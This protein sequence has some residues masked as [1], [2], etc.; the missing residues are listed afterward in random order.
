[1]STALDPGSGQGLIDAVLPLRLQDFERAT[2][3]FE[4]LLQNFEG[5]GTLWLVTR[6]EELEAV[7]HESQ[8]I[9]RGLDFRVESELSL[10]PELRLT[11]PSGWYRQ[12]LIKLAIAEHLSSELYLT[13]DADV[14]CTRKVKPRELA[15]GGRG[16]CYVIEK[17]LHPHWYTRSEAVLGLSAVRQGIVHNV[18]PAVLHRTAVRELAEYLD[19]R[20]AERKF[21][22]GMRGL[23]QRFA[24]VRAA[25][26]RAPIAPWRLL[27]AAGVPWTEYALYYT[28]LE[29]TQRFE[30]FH[31]LSP[32][33]LYDIERSVWYA[34]GTNFGDWDPGPCFVGE[35]PPWFV[36]IQSNTRLEPRVVRA[37]FS[38]FLQ[39]AP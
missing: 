23:K 27:L 11:K 25:L 13:L 12:Q 17:D 3:L 5:L 10:V 8:R 16:L 32:H 33:C 26:T 30:R 7:R 24:F 1:V 34:D 19:R 6:D 20:A 21:A 9:P 2:L 29:A 4:S 31:Q 15:P 28:F 36:V 39:Q 37:K 18:T 35:G 22:A 38:P 14:V